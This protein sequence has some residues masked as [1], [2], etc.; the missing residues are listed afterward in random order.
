MK[1]EQELDEIFRY[2]D[3]KGSTRCPKWQ[4]I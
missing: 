1:F 2:F 3:L 4:Q